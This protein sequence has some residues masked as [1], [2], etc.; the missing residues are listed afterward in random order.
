MRRLVSLGFRD[1]S[2]TAYTGP[3]ASCENR[4]IMSRSHP[5]NDG[6]PSELIAAAQKRWRS[7]PSMMMLS[8]HD[9]SASNT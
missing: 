6:S 2:S 8:F 1:V 7:Q 5:R 3:R 4:G 9:S